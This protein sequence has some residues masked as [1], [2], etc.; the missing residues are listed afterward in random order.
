MAEACD[1]AAP[2]D[3]PLVELDKFVG[4][5]GGGGPDALL[6]DLALHNFT[7][8][9]TEHVKNKSEKS[10]GPTRGWKCRPMTGPV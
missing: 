10:T 8:Q 5:D 1:P 3:F 2:A 7:V 9:S 6:N 4:R